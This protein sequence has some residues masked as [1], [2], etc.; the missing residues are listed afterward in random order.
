MRTAFFSLI[1]LLL[2]SCGTSVDNHTATDTNKTDTNK[3]APG[4]AHL[5]GIDISSYQG[6]EIDFINKKQDTLS[7]IICRA[8]LGIT[9]TDPDF[10]NNWKMISEKGFV[11]GAYHFYMCNDDP[12]KQAEHFIAVVG[13]LS[14]ND[15]PPILDFEELGLAGVTDANKIQSD[16]LTFLNAV[17]A[18]TGRTPMINVS[19]DFA[20]IYLTDPGFSKY[21]LWESD[22]INAAQPMLPSQWKSTGWTFWQ[23][24]DS[25]KVDG[26]VNDFDLFNGD[27]QKLDAFIQGK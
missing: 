14:P 13:T 11:R 21:P 20:A 2:I 19:P 8:S 1:I 15:L 9:F 26:N 7:F 6:D 22:Y 17:E 10:A 27:R 5:Y 18:G 12:T 25:V 16:V 23:K 24:T 4:T 3:V